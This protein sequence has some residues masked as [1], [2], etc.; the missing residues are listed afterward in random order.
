MSITYTAEKKENTLITHSVMEIH[1]KQKFHRFIAM[2]FF[3]NFAP[4]F[5][6]SQVH[7]CIRPKHVF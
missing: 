2:P 7:Q 6:Q 1:Y 3:E 4:P 5:A